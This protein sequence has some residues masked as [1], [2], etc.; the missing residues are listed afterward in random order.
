MTTIE[1]DVTFRAGLVQMCS[2]RDVARNVEVASQLV[3]EAAGM[4]AQYVQ[5]PEVTSFMELDRDAL[6]A[7]CERQNENGALKD[8]QALGDDLNIWLHIGSMP[9]RL[10][11]VSSFNNE[12]GEQVACFANRSFLIGPDGKIAAQYDTI[13]MFDVALANGETYFESRN[14]RPGEKA[15]VAA[16][17]WGGLGLTICYD[18]RFPYLH[19]AL[20]K[21]GASMIAVPAAFTRPTGSAHWHVLLRARAVETQCFVLAAAQCGQ[22]EHGRA[23][24]GHSVIIS[25][26]GEVLADG[27]ETPGV[28]VADIDHRLLKDVRERVPSLRHERNFD[29]VVQDLAD[30]GVE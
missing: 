6:I 26:W 25:P 23:T 29:V 24:Y 5:T 3:R 12:H 14:S 27:G 13:H 22:H 15:V 1:G 16:T 18:L 7:A 4:G 30:D 19:R 17:P 20:A 28:V 21:A 10:D 11:H 8:F 2:G 9:V